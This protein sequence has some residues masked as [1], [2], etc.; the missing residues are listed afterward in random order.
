MNLS[1]DCHIS[2]PLVESVEAEDQNS[3][4]IANYGHG[5]SQSEEKTTRW[6]MKSFLGV[7]RLYSDEV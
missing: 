5:N 4:E 6:L 3:D 7:I 1:C 2:I